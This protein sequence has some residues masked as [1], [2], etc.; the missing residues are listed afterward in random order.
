MTIKFILE[1]VIIGFSI[2]NTVFDVITTKY[3]ILKIQLVLN[4]TKMKI[5][6]VL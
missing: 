6:L 1:I 3:C 2:I 4:M 5:L